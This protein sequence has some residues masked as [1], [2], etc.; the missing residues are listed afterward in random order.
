MVVEDDNVMEVE[1]DE[2]DSG[3]GSQEATDNDV[4][5]YEEFEARAAEFLAEA[6]ASQGHRVEW[7]MPHLISVF[8][9]KQHIAFKGLAG[10]SISRAV[11]V[12]TEQV[13]TVRR[14]LSSRNVPVLTSMMLDFSSASYAKAV[15]KK[16]GYP[17]VL[18][19]LKGST[20]SVRVD[21][22][23]AF[24]VAFDDLRL[25][26]DERK[27][28]LL[29]ERAYSGEI[30]VAMVAEQAAATSAQPEATQAELEEAQELSRAALKALPGTPYGSV[31]LVRPHGTGSDSGWVVE[32][33]D[34][35]FRRWVDNPEPASRIAHEILRYEFTRH[36]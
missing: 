13:W 23:E 27:S 1:L 19:T 32:S 5:L 22:E 7:L 34:P 2:S 28:P 20:K 6:A 26:V 8:S 29:I 17:I 14:L 24:R 3:S 4:V 11:V 33:I 15:A 25:K 30:V 10:A 35:L 18:R 31:R 12:F 36:R 16:V 21:N 9:E